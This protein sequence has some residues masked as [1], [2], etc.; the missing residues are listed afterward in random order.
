MI[1]YYYQSMAKTAGKDFCDGSVAPFERMWMIFRSW[2]V[3]SAGALAL[4]QMFGCNTKWNRT[5]HSRMRTD[6]EWSLVTILL[7]LGA[8][9]RLWVPVLRALCVLVL[10]LLLESSA[11]RP[12]R[13]ERNTTICMNAYSSQRAYSSHMCHLCL[14]SPTTTSCWS[15][16]QHPQAALRACSTWC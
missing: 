10:P 12:C 3:L 8:V 6:V 1:R 9:G 14:G 15:S 16:R 2:P 5:R 13:L 11:L 4:L 7:V